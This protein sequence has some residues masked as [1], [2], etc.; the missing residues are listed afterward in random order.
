MFLLSPFIFGWHEIA[1]TFLVKLTENACCQYAPRGD[2]T[3]SQL[4]VPLETGQPARFCF[5]RHRAS[6]LGVSG[7]LLGTYVVELRST[8]RLGAAAL[9]D[10][11]HLGGLRLQ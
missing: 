4:D 1:V 9:R 8:G 3:A 6:T 10:G 5:G 2:V 11:D 7:L